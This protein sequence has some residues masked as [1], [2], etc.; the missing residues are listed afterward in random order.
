MSERDTYMDPA[1]IRHTIGPTGR[2]S[3][4]NVSGDI[5]L[6][7]TDGDEVRVVAES[8]HGHGEELPLIVRKSEG[9]LHIETDQK[10]FAL[11]GK[12]LSRGPVGIDF[13][14]SVPRDARIE[15]NSVSG[16]VEANELGGEQAYKSVSG[17]LS[18]TG[19]GGRVSM[20]TVSG[21]VE[22]T[23]DRPIDVNLTT[24]SGN[25][26]LS[27]PTIEGLQMRT[28]SG[29]MELRGAFAA[30]GQHA[31]E[32]VSG[33]LQIGAI[34][35]LTVDVRRGLDV[36]FGRGR[37]LVA[38]DGS[39]QLR[40]RSLSGDVDL[41]GALAEER[42]AR[43]AAPVDRPAQGADAQATEAEAADDQ[44][45]EYVPL[46]VEDSL[47]ILRALERGDIDVEEASRRLEGAGSR[48]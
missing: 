35:G 18:L 29:D 21:D 36:A 6:R 46:P 45:T 19:G 43:P 17:D 16:D 13:E 2:F 42:V 38:G 9:A 32:S 11:L 33:D 1:E 48:G 28:V 20:I 14:V 34:G 40:F 39:A 5:E 25:V 41:A 7:G 31:I 4:H 15:V 47:E 22:L 23:A 44:T 30:G 26:E 8:S 12:T 37:R 3:L 10:S 27:A 24:T